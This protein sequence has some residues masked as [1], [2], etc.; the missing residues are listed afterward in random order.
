M[1]KIFR[2][3]ELDVILAAAEGAEEPPPEPEG[4]IPRQ[5]LPGWIRWPIRVW[6]LPFILL[7]LGA[8]RI[9]RLLVPPP[10]K[11][12]GE[13]LKRGNCCYTI[14]VPEAKG[15]LGRLFYVWNTQ[16]LGFYRR[17]PGVYESQGKRV[18]VMGC[19]YLKKDG[20]CGHYRLRP[21]VCR[22]WPVIEYF[23]Y[24]RILRGCGFQAVPRQKKD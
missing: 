1:L 5:W 21:A 19:R 16:V 14:L 24:P 13:C 20:S 23:G 9:A 15:I 7:D 8:Q 12:E 6:V 4:G 18:H 2:E 11:R 10:L 3:E 22:K 17:Q